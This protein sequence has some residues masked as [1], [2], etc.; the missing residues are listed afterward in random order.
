ML[1]LLL[2]LQQL[3]YFDEFPLDTQNIIIR[4]GSF[5]YNS[6]FLQMDLPLDENP[7]SF[8]R[9]YNGERNFFQ[10]SEWGFRQN[11][12]RA[13]IYTTSTDGAYTD[14]AVILPMER[15]GNALVVRVGI[16]ITILLALAGITFWGATPE[17]RIGA[18]TT[19]LIAVAALY[20]VILNN[21]PWV[22]YATTMD[23]FILSVSSRTH[24]LLVA[25]TS[26]Y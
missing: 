6:T 9:N 21:V 7:I 18:A 26:E 20:I 8:V 14:V 24:L 2:T 22:G 25:L 13:L 10:N 23:T 15:Y 1:I 3:F 11:E 5:G 17:G 4:Y 16:P 19:I 12:E